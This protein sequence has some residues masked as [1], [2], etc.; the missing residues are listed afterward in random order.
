ML[1][2]PLHFTT[3]Q[4]GSSVR[5]VCYDEFEGEYID[6]WCEFQYSI[7]NMKSW[8]DYPKNGNSEESEIKLDKCENKTVYFRAKQGNVEG[9]PNL[10]GFY[11]DIGA[12]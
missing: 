1:K 9:N 4:D 2:V 6:T 11:T 12:V 3:E 8:N 5:F 10:N 7:D